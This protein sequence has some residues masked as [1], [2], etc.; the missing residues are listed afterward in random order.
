[1]KQKSKITVN[2]ARLFFMI[3]MVGLSLSNSLTGLASCLVII[4]Y[5]IFCVIRSTKAVRSKNIKLY[6]FLLIGT[7][8]AILLFPLSGGLKGRVALLKPT[9]EVVI[10]NQTKVSWIT[11]DNF[12]NDFCKIPNCS[13]DASLYYRALWFAYGLK[14]IER[15]PLGLGF[16]ELPLKQ[17]L[18]K[19]FPGINGVYASDFHS[20]LLT[21][22]VR[23]GLPGALLSLS[24]FFYCFTFLGN[25]KSIQVAP[26]KNLLLG[27][28]ICFFIRLTFDSAGR[29]VLFTSALII[30]LALLLL[31]AQSNKISSSS[32]KNLLTSD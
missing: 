6:K 9:L 32:I 4:F 20:D 12:V 30:L 14:I 11:P 29:Y 13:V 16:V 24:I 31:L 2:F 17:E 22:I 18:Q 8:F 7:I 19:E 10:H 1:M 26:A 15:N 27:C 3:A 5:E 23:F 25:I 21:F 28:L